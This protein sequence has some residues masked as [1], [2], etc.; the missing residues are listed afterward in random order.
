MIVLDCE[1]GSQAWIDARLRHTDRLGILAHRHAD[2]TAQ[3][4]RSRGTLPSFWPNGRSAIR[5]R[6]SAVTNGPN[7]A[8]IA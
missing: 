4:G 6:N 1:Q 7:A 8:R 5:S 3:H 2:W